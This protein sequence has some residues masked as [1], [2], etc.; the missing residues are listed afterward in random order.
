MY[1]LYFHKSPNTFKIAMM[2]EECGLDYRTQVVN[3]GAGEQFLPD[4]VAIS[5]NSKVP[6]LHDDAPAFGATP[7][8]IFES[9]AILLYLAE[10]TGRFLPADPL[11]KYETMQWLFWQVAS[12]S[13]MCG[14]SAHFQMFSP[15][16]TYA[17]ERYLREARRLFAVLDRRLDS[18][19]YVSGD[20]YSIADM[21]C[22]AWV[23]DRPRICLG[24]ETLD[25]YPNLARWAATVA[26]RSATIAAYAR[27]EHDEKVDLSL[28]DFAR[29]M[30]GQDPDRAKQ[31]ASS[32]AGT[33]ERV[34]L[35]FAPGPNTKLP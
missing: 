23:E 22:Y 30:F 12:M 8:N 19:A 26:M 33:L 16:T 31:S 28:A 27:L 7:V 3:V 1:N 10:K 5:P 14:Q 29:N 34:G 2:L 32:A 17:R 35:R 25:D 20:L 21:A 24:I 15:E 9:G 11:G 13:P 18:R 4:F 6:V